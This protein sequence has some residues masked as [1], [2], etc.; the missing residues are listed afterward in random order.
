MSY[1]IKIEQDLSWQTQADWQTPNTPFMQFAYWQALIDSQA[2]GEGSDWATLFIVL[3]ND[4]KPMACLPLFIKD[5]HKGEYVFDHAW[6]EAYYRYGK[7]YYP[8]LVT[9]VPFTPVTGERIWLAKDVTLTDQMWQAFSQAIDQVATQIKAS[10][11]HGLFLPKSLVEMDKDKNLLRLGCQFRWFNRN[12][13]GKKFAN[14]DNFLAILTAKK[15]KSIKVERQKVAKQ[16]LTSRIKLGKDITTDDWQIFYQCYAMTYLVRGRQPYLTLDFFEQIGNTM[17]DNLMLAQ[18]LGEQEQ[19]VA[20]ALFFYDSETLYGRYWGCLAEYNSLHFEL[21]YYQGIEFAI[22]QGLSEFDPGTQG[23]H[24]LIRGFMPTLSYSLHRVY[25]K[26]FERAIANFC[27]Q[28]REAVMA[29]YDDA[30][31]AVPFNHD[32]LTSLEN[33]N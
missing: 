27:E 18:A 11:W 14:F 1:L 32:Y 13:N 28:E 12:K 2:I 9:S 26:G 17:S 19:V 21:C 10:T 22:K 6:A 31:T 8:R 16:N 20:C 29:Y 3:K 4:D 33:N 15:R 5:H 25:D 24:K 30:M 7:E 23:E